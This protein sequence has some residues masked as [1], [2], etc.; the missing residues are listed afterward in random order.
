MQG[1]HEPAGTIVAMGDDAKNSS[2]YKAIDSRYAAAIPDSMTFEQAAPLM[3]AGAT[4]Y[5]SIKV[6]EKHGLKAGGTIGF[7]GLGALG[8]LGVQFAKTMS[9]K[10][11]GVDA[12]KEPVELA[13]RLQYPP[14]LVLNSKEVDAETAREKVVKLDEQK[15]FHGLDAAILLAD[16]QESID[17]AVKLLARHG[18]LVLVSQPQSGIHLDFHE[19]VFRDIRLVG[20][21]LGNP[22]DLQAT[23]DLC[24]KHGIES[25]L[26]TYRLEDINDLVKAADSAKK[27]GKT[28][29]TFA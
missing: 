25:T 9:Y 21:L 7:V 22:D 3:C 6:A 5:R 26:V 27:S 16:P 12:R 24:A 14:D 29:I 28:V 2:K 20:S 18:L 11:V 1:S 4:I 15:P 10:V 19:L 17:Y 13:T 23:V 8:H